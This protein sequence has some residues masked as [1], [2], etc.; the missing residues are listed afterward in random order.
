MDEKVIIFRCL[1]DFKYQVKENEA[2]REYWCPECGSQM[3]PV[4]VES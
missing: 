1:C 2:G 3:H 4:T